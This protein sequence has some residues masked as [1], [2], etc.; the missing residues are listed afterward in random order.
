MWYTPLPQIT[1]I[2]ILFLPLEN[3]KYIGYKKGILK[4]ANFD[5][6]RAFS[7]TTENHARSLAKYYELRDV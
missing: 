4:L 5:L 7:I 1:I 2:N 6:S 3:I